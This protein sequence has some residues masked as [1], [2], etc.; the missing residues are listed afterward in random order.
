M[1]TLSLFLFRAIRMG[2]TSY[3]SDKQVDKMFE[4]RRFSSAGGQRHWWKACPRQQDRAP[5]WP[6]AWRGH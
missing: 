5:A 2:L 3:K 1:L 4:T 6:A